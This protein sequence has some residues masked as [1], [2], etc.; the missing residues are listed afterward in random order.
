MEIV[1]L[2]LVI[3]GTILGIGIV[4]TMYE[5]MEWDVLEIFE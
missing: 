4:V 1:S 2:F 3:G 5:W